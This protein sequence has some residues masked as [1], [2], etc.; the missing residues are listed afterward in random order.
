M[1]GFFGLLST[2]FEI[3]WVPRML[4]RAVEVSHKDLFQVCP[5]LDSIWTEGVPTMFVPNQPRTMEGFE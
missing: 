1:K 2:V 5:T 3:P 4:V